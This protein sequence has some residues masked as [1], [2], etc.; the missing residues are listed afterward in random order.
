[1]NNRLLKITLLFLLVIF[2]RPVYC[3]S[4][5]TFDLTHSKHNPERSKVYMGL[6]LGR[7]SYFG[8]LDNNSL[9][10]PFYRPFGVE[11]LM[12][13]EIIRSIRL[14]ASF[15]SG[16]IYGEE[17][18]AKRN[19]N[20]KTSLLV[21]QLGLS[22]RIAQLFQ[23]RF[24]LF[25]FAGAEM[26]FF[27]PAGDLKS[28]LGKTYYYWDDGTVR[29][30]SEIPANQGL[31]SI[32]KPD[33]KYEADYRNLN[34]DNVSKYPRA[35]FSIPV[36]LWVDANLNRGFDLRVGTLFHYTFTD[37]LD[38]ITVNS[39]GS[40]KGNAAPDQFLYTFVGL[41][42]NLPVASVKRPS[43]NDCIKDKVQIDHKKMAKRKMK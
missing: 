22:F 34:I 7:N 27:N 5:P 4:S 17:R 21:P 8:D 43:P 37:Y 31:A 19:L 28:A 14:S 24:D 29:D 25:F 42:Y 33:L 41:I 3:K 32:I 40:R 16:S 11:I 35:A 10:I 39:V 26:V 9:H 15:F 20:F 13:R 12:E 1:M 18:S 36:G 23:Q 30:M 2:I 6:C 38:N